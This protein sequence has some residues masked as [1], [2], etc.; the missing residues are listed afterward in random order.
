[1]LLVL[2]ALLALLSLLLVSLLDDS[3]I[4]CSGSILLAFRSVNSLDGARGV[5]GDPTPFDGVI[6][7]DPA[8]ANPSAMS[9]IEETCLT[10]GLLTRM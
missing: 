8:S 4:A 9:M 6:S 7:E 5:L 2:L 10:S 3:S 1:M